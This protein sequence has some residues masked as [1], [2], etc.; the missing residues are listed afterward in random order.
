M[1]TD[2]LLAKTHIRM[3]QDI[4]ISY[5]EGVGCCKVN[6]LKY[7][8]ANH[9]RRNLPLNDNTLDISCIQLKIYYTKHQR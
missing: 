9:C 1:E 8:I 5:Y 3:F 7:P 2:N 6:K 4:L